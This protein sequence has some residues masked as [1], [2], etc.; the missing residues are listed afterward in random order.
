L[1][2]AQAAGFFKKTGNI[3]DLLFL[4]GDLASIRS[5]PDFQQLVGELREAKK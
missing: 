3:L 5:R 4:N 1:R 2:R